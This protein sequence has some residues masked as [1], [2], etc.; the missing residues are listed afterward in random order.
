MGLYQSILDLEASRLRVEQ[1]GNSNETVLTKTV[2]ISQNFEKLR[3][4]CCLGCEECWEKPR[5]CGQSEE[6]DQ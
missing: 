1:V 2:R 3:P 6:G 5:S 4:I